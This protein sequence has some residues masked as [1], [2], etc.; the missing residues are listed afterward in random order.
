VPSNRGAVESQ[1]LLQLGDAV[2][3]HRRAAELSQEAL[4]DRSGL[5]G[6]YI[7]GIERGER[8]ASLINLLRLA[9]AL[10]VSAAELVAGIELRAPR[11]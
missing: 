2:R 6:T 3:S 10:D 8:N 4:A 7:G 9:D 11:G 1:A 5:H